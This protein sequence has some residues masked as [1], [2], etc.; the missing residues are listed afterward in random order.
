AAATEAAT[1]ADPAAVLDPANFDATAINA[2][3]D[4]SALEEST[5]TVLKSAIDAAAKNPALQRLATEQVKAALG[6]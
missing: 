2:L 5:K 1:A 3:I 6:L 4:A